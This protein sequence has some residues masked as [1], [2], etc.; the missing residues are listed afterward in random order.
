MTLAVELGHGR[1]A[2]GRG[3]LDERDTV[4]VSERDLEGVGEPSLDA[5]AEHDPVDE[6]LDRVRLRLRESNVLGELAHGAVDPNA[7]EAAPTKLVELLPVLAL[8]LADDRRVDPEPAPVGMTDEPIDDLL[9]GLRRDRLAALP[10]ERLADAR[11]EQ[12]KVV[13][14]L[15]DRTDRRAWVPPDA[16]LLDRDRRREAVDAL[17]IGLLH[18]LEELPRVGGQ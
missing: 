18:L 17:A 7:H 10:T 8:S 15:R 9:H 11:E 13:G 6:H 3:D 1:L 16:A 5:A 2:A 12:P 14:Q 4:A